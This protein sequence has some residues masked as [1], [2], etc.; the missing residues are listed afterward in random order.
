MDLGN[1][2]SVGG[3]V[4]NSAIA[5]RQHCAH[6]SN[7]QCL[8]CRVYLWLVNPS[9]RGGGGHR[10][11]TVLADFNMGS[12]SGGRWQRKRC[13]CTGRSVIGGA[14]DLDTRRTPFLLFVALHRAAVGEKE[15]PD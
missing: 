2:S 13:I 15:G 10:L 14:D 11:H 12:V 1:V 5:G 7:G 8:L 6:A 9:L 3:P 4:A